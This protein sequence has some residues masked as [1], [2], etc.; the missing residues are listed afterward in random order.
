MWPTRR[1]CLQFCDS[2]IFNNE[3][4]IAFLQVE[5]ITGEVLVSTIVEWLSSHNLCLADIHGQCYD[6]ASST[7]GARS[8]CKA[9]VIR[10]KLK[11]LARVNVSP[12]QLLSIPKSLCKVGW[13]IACKAACKG[14]RSSRRVAQAS[15]LSTH[16]VLHTSFS[17]MTLGVDSSLSSALSNKRCLFGEKLKN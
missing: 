7:S 3:I 10:M 16:H 6:G 5:I 4:K 15:I 12:S 1:S 14:K 13:T 11:P 17:F 9:I 2:Y 8:G